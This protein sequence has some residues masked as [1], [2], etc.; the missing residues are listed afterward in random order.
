MVSQT[1]AGRVDT[2]EQKMD[3]L[4]DLPDR[5]TA[6]ESQIVQFRAD[7]GVEFSAVRSEMRTMEKSCAAMVNDRDLRSEVRASSRRPASGNGGTQP[8]DSDA[9]CRFCTRYT[10]GSR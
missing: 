2:L 7:V 3:R 5:M 10:T 9:G 1:V 8:R 4:E 6:L